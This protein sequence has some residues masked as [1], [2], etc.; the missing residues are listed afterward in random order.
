M[1]D[2]S[3]YDVA[4]DWAAAQER[5]GKGEPWGAQWG[6]ERL[7]KD[8]CALICQ[9]ALGKRVLEIGCGGGKWTKALFDRCGATDVTAIDVHQISLDEAAAYEPR[10]T[11][12]LGD[13]DS[14]PAEAGA[15]FG[16]VFTYDV[17]L[18]LPP[19]L[20]VKYLQDAYP[21]ARSMFL[22]M[23]SLDREVTRERFMLR[24]QAHRYRNPYSIGYVNF[25]TDDHVCALAEMAG[26]V[27]T[28]IGG[29]RR[30]SF[31]ILR[32]EAELDV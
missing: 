6:G 10:A 31:W 8:V 19:G 13:G 21:L 4:D 18:H 30:D 29:N 14:I 7:L 11:Y 16:L 22:Q 17:F 26:W 20:V 28:I 9:Y 3:I 15:G 12:L 32:K 24:V 27:P 1:S 23:P 5:G 2:Q 25:Y